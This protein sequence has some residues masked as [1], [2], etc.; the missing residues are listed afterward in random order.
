MSAI[1]YLLPSPSLKKTKAI[2]KIIP[3]ASET[4]VYR[5]WQL[6]NMTLRLVMQNTCTN[7]IWHGTSIGKGIYSARQRVQLVN[8]T[9]VHFNKCSSTSDSGKTTIHNIRINV[10]F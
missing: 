8:V 3:T 6:P 2:R 9:G 1:A 5:T 7:E 10:P 4:D